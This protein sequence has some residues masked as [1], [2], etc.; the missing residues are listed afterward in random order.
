MIYLRYIPS[1]PLNHYI[2]HLYYLDGLMPFP[3]ERILP[4]P[5]LDLKI[6]LGGAFLMYKD[7]H[8]GCPRS[9]TESWLVGLYGIY[10]TIDWPSEMRL[11]GVRFKPGGAYPFL[12]LP[13][14]ELYNQVVSLDAF[15][16]RFASEIRERL[17]AAPTI[18]TGL[19]LFEQLILTRLYEKPNEQNVVEYA[20]A[21][22]DRHHGTLSIR[23]LSDSV[24]I[25]QNHLGTQFKRIVGTS[26]KEMARLYRFEHVLRSTDPTRPVDWTQ[27]A[28]Q[29]GYYDQSHLDKDF[30]VFT[31]HNPT[32]YLHSRRRVYT[33]NAQ[34]DQF[35]L[36]LLPID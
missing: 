24:G 7:G 5:T 31:G 8:T 11:Y 32:G 15:W 27:I 4:V 36:R 12:G 26:V 16:G 21:M 22:I 30:R 13:M 10:H 33:D 3:Q 29:C 1:P 9:F 23:G 25:S 14:S 20:I 18:Q 35:S 2:E 19:A 17:Y 28:Q 34:V 6:N